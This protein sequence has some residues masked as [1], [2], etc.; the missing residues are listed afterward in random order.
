M[1]EERAER[2]KTAC[3]GEYACG[4]I[5]HEDAVTEARCVTSAVSAEI[6]RAR[7]TARTEEVRKTAGGVYA[8]QCR[9]RENVFDIARNVI[10]A[11]ATGGR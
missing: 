3:H 11:Q 6:C 8:N 9:H 5:I 4:T 1:R 2:Y 7:Y 10:A